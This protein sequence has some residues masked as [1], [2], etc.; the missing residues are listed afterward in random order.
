MAGFSFEIIA[1]PDLTDPR[2][3]YLLHEMG[4]ETRH[5]RLFVRLLE[6]V[7]PHGEEPHRRSGRPHRAARAHAVPHGN[8]VAVLP[9]RSERRR[10][11]GPPSEAG[12]RAPRHRPDDQG[13]LEVP[14]PGRSTPP[15]LR[16]DDLPRAVGG[17]RTRS[18]ASSS[19]TSG[20]TSPRRCSTRS[21]TPACTRRSASRLGRHGRRS[22]A[23]P[24]G[25]AMRHRA[26][27]PLLNQLLDADVFR[28]GL[29]PKGWQRA[30]GVDRHGRELDAGGGGLTRWPDADEGR[31]HP[32]GAAGGGRRALRP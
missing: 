11:P 24:A 22:I 15:R 20:R 17:G 4:E 10:G 6:Q 25:R 3:T 9:P 21:S 2:V 27:R 26:L 18:S 29:V 12:E 19:A 28:G 31:P 8:A 16:P 1:K 30:C 32:A 13:G 5:S 7:K 14:P 23:R